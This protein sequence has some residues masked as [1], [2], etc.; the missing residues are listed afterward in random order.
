MER[1]FAAMERTIAERGGGPAK[2]EDVK[3]AKGRILQ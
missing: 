2:Y 1:A 3:K